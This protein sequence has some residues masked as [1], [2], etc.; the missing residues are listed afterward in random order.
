M[1]KL[2]S[3]LLAAVVLLPCA[4][5]AETLHTTLVN[6]VNGTNYYIYVD[7]YEHHGRLQHWGLVAPSGHVMVEAKHPGFAFF[8]DVYV[9]VK[10]IK[11]VDAE[12]TIC[13]VKKT[14][15]NTGLHALTE[16]VHFD[17][18]TCTIDPA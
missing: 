9:Y 3:L 17:G 7:S 5:N 1:N 8:T 14:F 11:H 6:V 10:R 15:G 2:F 13:T 16:H 18:K 4:A 12:D